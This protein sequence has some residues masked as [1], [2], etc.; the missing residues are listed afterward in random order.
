MICTLWYLFTLNL[1]PWALSYFI[2]LDLV[3]KSI[4]RFKF[5]FDYIN[6]H[7]W[8]LSSLEK[9]TVLNLAHSVYVYTFYYDFLLL[10]HFAKYFINA[11]C[12]KKYQIFVNML[13]FVCSI[14]RELAFTAIWI[15]MDCDARQATIH[16][17]ATY[18]LDHYWGVEREH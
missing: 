7:N 9:G 5:C 10:M 11:K 15:L 6:K 17:L 16:L 8:Q 2:F 18:L 3:N 1:A 4:S 13:I 12:F 14:W